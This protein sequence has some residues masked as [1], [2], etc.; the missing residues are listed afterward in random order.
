MLAL[1]ALSISGVAAGSARDVDAQV[2]DYSPP[3]RT[4]SYKVTDYGRTDSAKD[5]K[6]SKAK[7]RVIE[8]TGNCCENYLST[9]KDGRLFDLG[10]SYIN[11]TDDN[12]KTWKS[13]RPPTGLVNGEGAISMAPGGDVVGIEWD[14]YSGDHLLSYRYDGDTEKWEYMEAPLH[15]PF[16]DRPWLTV[17]PGPFTTPLGEV[18]YVVFVDGAPHAGPTLYSTDG[19]TYVQVSAPAVDRL[20]STPVDGYLRTA[21]DRQLD[22]VMPN[23]NSPIVP[24]GNGYA[25]AVPGLFADGYSLFNPENQKWSALVGPTEVDLGE[26]FLV[27]SKGR[28]HDVKPMGTQFEYRISKD[29]G[30][31]WKSTFVP[32]PAGISI[33]ETD[34]KL[35]AKLGIAAL[36][37]HGT[38]GQADRDLLYKFDIRGKTA[39]LT[40]L[41]EIGLG[42]I[43]ASS[44]VGQDIRFDFETVAIFPDGRLAVS[45]LDSTT[46]PAITL[47]EAVADRLGPA[48][49]IEL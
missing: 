36:G 11:Y 30:K 19:L 34:L 3:I 15:T 4:E 6:V 43:N 20:D 41:Y 44:G 28:V 42:D 49:A 17:V 46:G 25:V 16:Y 24:L 29:G 12:G 23:N 26:G 38:T 45:F 9:N 13:V 37:I 10:G 47:T 39:R 40:K 14:P 32:L 21:K 48:L 18:A 33:I 5:D 7:F 31:S 2:V 1:L 8:R 22:W 27:D 35:N